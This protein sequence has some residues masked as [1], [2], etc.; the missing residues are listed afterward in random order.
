MA[1]KLSP[2]LATARVRLVKSAD[3]NEDLLLW[4]VNVH[5]ANPREPSNEITV[6]F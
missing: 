1:G 5:G 6:N 2:N 3:F 4:D